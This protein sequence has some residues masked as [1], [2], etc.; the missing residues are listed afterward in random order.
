[1]KTARTI[2]FWVAAFL[3]LAVVNVQIVRKQRVLS[4]GRRVLLRLAP[5]DPR[6]LIQGD[7]MTLRYAIADRVPRSAPANGLLVVKLDADGVA[8]FV[9]VHNGG[10]LEAGELLLR[11]RR[12]GRD[13]S[14]PR[15]RLGA[16][17]FFFQEGHAAI[18]NRARYGLLMVD[19]AGNSVLAGLC[20]ENRKRLGPP[21]K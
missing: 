2:A 20:G 13:W 4:R 18:Y 7:Y 1:M 6:S 9:R 19:D 3:V 10:P 21:S 14:G 15:V 11:Y 8:C 16:E 12:R 5:V 17:A